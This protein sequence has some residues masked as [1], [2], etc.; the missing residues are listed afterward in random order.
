MRNFYQRIYLLG[1]IHGYWSILLQHLNHVNE[2]ENCYIQVGDFGIGFDEVENEVERL[3]RLND[4][5]VEYDSHLYIIRGNHDNPLWFKDDEYVDIKSGLT[6]IFFLPDYSV[7]NIND[8]NILFIG[9]AVSIDR[10]YRRVKRMGWW[11]EEVVQFDFEKAS[12][13]RNIDRVICHTAPSFCKPLTFNQLVYDFAKQ[14]SLLLKD[15]KEEREKMTQLV[16][17][18]MK[19]NKIKSYVYGHFHNTYRFFHNDCEFIC[20]NVNQFINL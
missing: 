4:R 11:P 1:D 10:N 14:D 16:T 3:N 13:F 2:K 7:L 5:L 9:G 20:L 15:L 17:E 19:N 12:Q 8:E 6:N 18:I